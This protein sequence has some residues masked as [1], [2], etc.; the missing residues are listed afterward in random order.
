MLEL[1]AV[2]VASTVL[3]RGSHREMGLLSDYIFRFLRGP[4]VLKKLY[5]IIRTRIHTLLFKNGFDLNA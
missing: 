3:R 5:L 1:C 4:H 2:K